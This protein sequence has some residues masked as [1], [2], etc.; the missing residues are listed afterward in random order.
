MYYDETRH[1]LCRLSGHYLKA[2]YDIRY[3]WIGYK[4]QKCNEIFKEDD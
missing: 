3:N 1:Y 2:L 4:C